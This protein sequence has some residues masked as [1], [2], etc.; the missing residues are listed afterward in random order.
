MKSAG[1]ANGPV[2]FKGTAV[3][4][5]PWAA[6]RLFDHLVTAQENGITAVAARPGGRRG[7]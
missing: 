4:Y 3:L 1:A 5:V 2:P 7:P 6:K